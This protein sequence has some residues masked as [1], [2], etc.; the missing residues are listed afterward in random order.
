M[1]I[2]TTYLSDKSSTQ[3]TQLIIAAGLTLAGLVFVS[4][5]FWKRRKVSAAYDKYAQHPELRDS[6]LLKTCDL[7]DDDH[8][9]TS[10]KT[11]SSLL[12]AA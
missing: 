10:T 8:L 11:T 3:K 12:G 6:S 1:N 9:Y 5:A 4:L 2:E 7:C